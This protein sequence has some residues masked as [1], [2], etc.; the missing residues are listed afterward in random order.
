MVYGYPVAG[1][2]MIPEVV[3]LVN[4]RIEQNIPD[5]TVAMKEGAKVISAEGKLVGNVE[6][7][8]AEGPTEQITHLL[9]SSGIFTK[10]TKLIPITWV[11]T[12]DE[13]EVRLYVKKASVKKLPDTSTAIAG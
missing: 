4:T 13:D 7:I 2:S 3:D 6:H 9:V 12:I 11:N 10:E 1:M 5:G 8:L